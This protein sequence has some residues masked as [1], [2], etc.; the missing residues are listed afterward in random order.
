[1][2]EERGVKNYMVWYGYREIIHKYGLVNAKKAHT[3]R[4]CQICEDFLLCTD[5]EKI[6]L[7]TYTV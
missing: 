6:P 2:Y 4:L 5:M 1:M 3:K 7:C